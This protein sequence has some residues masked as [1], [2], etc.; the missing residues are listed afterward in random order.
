MRFILKTRYQQDIDF[1]KHNGQRFWYGVLFL[2]SIACLKG[3][4]AGYQDLK[5]RIQ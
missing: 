3:I 1:F 2:L 5:E 4:T